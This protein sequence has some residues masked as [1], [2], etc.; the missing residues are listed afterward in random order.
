MFNGKC[1]QH[2]ERFL[3]S[4][5]EPLYETLRARL[6]ATQREV[7]RVVYR[8]LELAAYRGDFT[9]ARRELSSLRE[10]VRV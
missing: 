8:R 5:C 9:G 4:E 2:A 1:S 10:M 6:D 7:A 3:E